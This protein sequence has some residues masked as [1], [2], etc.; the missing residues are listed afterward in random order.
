MKLVSVKVPR[1]SPGPAR[2]EVFSYRLDRYLI[3]DEDAEFFVKNT[4]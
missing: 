1:P 2:R 4:S 3:D